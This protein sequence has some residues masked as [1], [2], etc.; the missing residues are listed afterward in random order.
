MSDV[1]AAKTAL[2]GTASG[3]TPDT[4]DSS[5]IEGAKRYADD[6]AA[7]AETNAKAYADGLVNGETGI[8]KKVEALEAKHAEGKTVAEEVTAGI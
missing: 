1:N 3:E 6:K 2:V 4:K 7:T 8:I 5:T